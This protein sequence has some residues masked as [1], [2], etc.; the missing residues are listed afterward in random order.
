MI[1][2]RTRVTNNKTILKLKSKPHAGLTVVASSNGPPSSA[3]PGAGAV[4]NHVVETPA[5]LQAP[6][7][8]VP[9]SAAP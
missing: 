3:P 7:V 9:L 1:N 8:D 2:K 4:L 5:Q 6:E